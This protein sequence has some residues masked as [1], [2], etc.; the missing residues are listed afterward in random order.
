[1]AP[2]EI[3]TKAVKDRSNENEVRSGT[4]VRKK[5]T[6]APVGGP[7]MNMS[8][9]QKGSRKN[10]RLRWVQAITTARS[11]YLRDQ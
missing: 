2:T 7:F 4:G 11:I 6:A 1:M 5:R 9:I 3:A 10:R 8:E